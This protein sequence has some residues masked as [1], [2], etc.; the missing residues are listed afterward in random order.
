MEFDAAVTDKVW[1]LLANNWYSILINGQ[2]QDFFHSTRGV[3]Q[4]DP[5]S[6]ALLVL[7]AE[8]LSRAFNSLFLVPDFK[9]FGMP[10]WSDQINHL[11][12]ANDTIIFVSADKKSVE[13]VMTTLQ[14]YELQSGQLVNKQKSEFFM[15]GNFKN[16]LV[17]EVRTVTAFEK[18][19]FPIIYLGC[20]IIHGKE[21]KV[22]FFR[23]LGEAS[24]G[25][26]GLKFVNLRKEED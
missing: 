10:K 15:H 14:K 23:K 17:D 1:R 3:K 19:K 16:A 24:I 6:P 8:V 12:Y 5:L 2:A 11:A 7:T 13:M 26:H 22:S 4:G 25:L 21:E 20:P 18:G 9:G